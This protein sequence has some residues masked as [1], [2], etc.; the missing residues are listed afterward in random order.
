MVYIVGGQALTKEEY[1][2]SSNRSPASVT[3]NGQP[4]EVRDTVAIWTP[5]A[6]FDGRIQVAW[7]NPDGSG[8]A[9]TE[10]VLTQAVTDCDSPRI[11]G[12]SVRN[13]DKDVDGDGLNT[14]GITLEFN[15]VV[16]GEGIE[17]YP[18]GGTP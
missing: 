11:T 13:G 16:V 9:G 14:D 12:G 7:K 18:E 3:V 4:A 1:A 17:I 6:P 5:T 15:M 2:R 8:G 10:I